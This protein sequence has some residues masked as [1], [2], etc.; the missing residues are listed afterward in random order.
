MYEDMCEDM[1]A[2][3]YEYKNKMLK[4]TH[5]KESCAMFM[6]QLVSSLPNCSNQ[7]NEI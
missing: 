5:A 1:H 6:V 3:M 2:D 4:K 7:C